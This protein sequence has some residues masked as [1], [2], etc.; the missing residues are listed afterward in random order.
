VPA[1]IGMLVNALYNVVDRI[2]IGNIPGVGSMAIA[3]LGVTMPIATIIL[4]FGMLV[5]VG[6]ATNV[7]I[8]LG[9]GKKEEAQNI[10]GSG[11][12]LSVIIGILLTVVGI[13]FCDQILNM[14]GASEATLSYAKAYTNILLFVLTILLTINLGLAIKYPNG[15]TTGKDYLSTPYYFFG[16]KNQT[17]PI[18]LLM[19]MLSFLKVKYTKNK[20]ECLC[21][22]MIIILNTF[23]MKSGT[24]LVCILLNLILNIFF[25]KKR[26]GWYNINNKN[27]SILKKIV[28]CVIILMIGIVF[29]DLQKKFSWLIIDILKKDVTLSGRTFL[30][31]KGI[32][33]FFQKPFCGYGYGHKID[34]G[35]YGHNLIIELMVTTGILGVSIYFLFLAKAFAGPEIARRGVISVPLICAAIALIV[36]NI[37]EAFIY[38]ISQMAILCYMAYASIRIKKL[39]E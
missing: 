26:L 32:Y 23:I 7:S 10:I 21:E 31:K 24:G 19:S 20:A 16:T 30:W 9:Q 34:L 38:N 17:T 8:K 25:G 36:G 18:L 22:N 39:E 1:I 14:F 11:M 27:I 2:F 35:L 37:S 6:S 15:I 28:C 12:I 13:I 5:G 33:Q 3:G 29:F 4:A